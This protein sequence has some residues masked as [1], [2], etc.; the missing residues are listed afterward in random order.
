MLTLLV[1]LL[2]ALAPAADLSTVAERSGFVRTGR[3]DEV[4]RL[5][6]AFAQRWP[7]NV[8]CEVFGTTPEGRAMNVL[9]VADDLEAAHER[10]VILVQG[11][12]HAGEIDGK[13]AGL[14]FLRELL[15]G[16]VAQGA[17]RSATFVFVPVYNVDGHERMSKNNR[18]NQRGP[19]EMGWRT[20]SWNLN[21]NRDYMKAEAPETR[22]MIGLLR[23][24]RPAL[25][26]DLHVTDG[27]QFQHDVAVMIDG[28]R[29]AAGAMAAEAVA[30]QARVLAA[31]NNGGHAALDFY[32]AFEKDDD[33]T[34]GFSVGIAPPRFS[35][36]YWAQHGGI[37][38]LVETHSWKDYRTRVQTTHDVLVAIFDD[39]K[40]HVGEWRAPSPSSTVVLAWENTDDKRTI[41]FLG[42]Q[43]TR[44]LSPI[45]GAL[46]TTYDES[47]PEVWK[48]PLV[49]GLKPALVVTAPKG[50]YLVPAAHAAWMAERLALHGIPYLVVDSTRAVPVE[51]F[52][53]ADVAFGTKP[54]EGRMTAK[55]KG[56]W[57]KSR[58]TLRANDV[59][60]RA[61]PLAVHLLEPTAPDSLASW[62]YFNANFEQKEYMEAYVAEAVAVEMLRDPKVREEFNKKL[63]DDLFANS[64]EQRL[65]FFYRKHPS[66]DA[67]KDVYPVMRLLE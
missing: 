44:E 65:D 7:K 32:P 49:T 38:M 9:V 19:A 35:Q 8:R 11:G 17:L 25:Y 55:I 37:G 66:Y 42:Y 60:V 28:P 56:A 1:A 3:Y 53:A 18:P 52:K 51:V 10:P 54:Y 45:S 61:T 50:G 48:V 21:L 5:C 13:D 59:I 47:K 41:D 63:E 34:S 46:R 23:T 16:T 40:A 2:P 36:G 15:E 57:S 43:Y 4:T 6:G 58:V 12:I 22:A 62:G 39:A 30:M 33:P 64:P 27:A 31:L 26:V 20:T 67:Q 14:W 29:G 24:W